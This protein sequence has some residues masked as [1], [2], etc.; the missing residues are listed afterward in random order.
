M[1]AKLKKLLLAAGIVAAL[2]VLTVLAKQKLEQDQL[3]VSTNFIMDTVIEQKLYGK[4]AQ[5]A[6]EEIERRLRE[7]EQE[8][9]MYLEESLVSRINQNAG[10]EYTE[11]TPQ[12]LELI[13]RSIWFSE[14]SNGLFDIT[15]APLTRLWNIT[16]ENP[17]VPS[18]EEIA[19]ARELVNYRDILVDGNRV[20]LRRKGQA[21]DLGAVAKGA[22]CTIVWEA[23]EQYHIKTGYVSIGG[24]L[25]VLGEDR[26]GNPYRFGIRDPQGDASQAIGSIS[27]T[28]K[29]MATT[30]AYER[31]FEQDGVRYHHVLDPR[32]GYPAE[33]DL[34]SVSVISQDGM[35]ADCLSTT[36]FIEGKQEAL[37]RMNEQEY[38][39]V[40]VDKQGTVYCSESLRGNFQP[41][42][43][44][45]GQYQYVFWGE[46][47]Q[48]K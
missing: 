5:Q 6:S 41:D 7:Y 36:L 9:S 46:D 24:N 16:G 32:T 37:R 8:C 45:T 29:T 28:G 48:S 19:Q 21:I 44:K 35:L 42:E 4:E 20:M 11:V 22:A 47:G 31:W 2:G 15:I 34:L 40:I 38:Q 23:A 27:L 13:E 14:Q 3:F 39:L 1:K 43:D 10:L 17:R 33:S 30:G 12:C 18:D 26:Q 25:V